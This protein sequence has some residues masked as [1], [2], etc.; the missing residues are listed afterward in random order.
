MRCELHPDCE[1]DCVSERVRL[2]LS[3]A[4]VLRERLSDGDVVVLS[5][6]VAV[7]FVLSERN[8]YAVAA[9]L[10]RRHV[11]VDEDLNQ[12]LEPDADAHD[13]CEPDAH[14]HGIC[15]PDAHRHGISEFLPDCN[16]LREHDADFISDCVLEPLPHSIVYSH[17][18]SESNCDAVVE[19]QP[20]SVE[21]SNRVVCP[22]CVAYNLPVAEPVVV[23]P[24]HRHV[25]V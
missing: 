8:L 13:V 1:L 22:D 7:L 6:S 17:V 16:S 3:D 5:I 2:A 10:P 24:S 11:F 25:H 9:D 19:Q 14:R 4:V 23:R 21:V 18:D 15:E 20:V 12:Q